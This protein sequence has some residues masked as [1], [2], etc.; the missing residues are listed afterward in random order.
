MDYW[1]SLLRSLHSP[2]GFCKIDFAPSP[3]ACWGGWLPLVALSCSS[4]GTPSLRLPL[5]QGSEGMTK[6]VFLFLLALV[7]ILPNASFWFDRIALVRSRTLV[8]A[9]LCGSRKLQTSRSPWCYDTAPS[10]LCS[11]PGLLPIFRSVVN[12]PRTMLARKKPSHAPPEEEEEPRG[13]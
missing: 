12:L 3:L 1:C 4:A 2:P 13:N 9:F 5:L 8:S 6:H 11:G 10:C 7:A